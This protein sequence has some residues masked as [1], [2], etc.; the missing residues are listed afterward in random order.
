[1]KKE[2]KWN[3]VINDTRYQ[4][5]FAQ[6][7]TKFELYVDGELCSQ[8]IKTNYEDNVEK[9]VK[10][11]GKVCQ[12]VVYGE[13]PDLVVDGIMMAADAQEQKTKRFHRNVLLLFGFAQIVIG[14]FAGY[15]W[16]TMTMA[17]QKVFGGVLA[18][19]GILVFT[20]AGVLELLWGV[21][22]R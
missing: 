21:K 20:G 8:I 3:I 16:F 18:L 6:R 10:I 14:T 7:R 2:Q 22:K 12:F 5:M 11:D 15:L 4:I 17:G 19:L 13:D 1:M 9:D